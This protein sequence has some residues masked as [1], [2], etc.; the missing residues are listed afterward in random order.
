VV[1]VPPARF[2]LTAPLG[3]VLARGEDWTT[4]NEEVV[5]AGERVEVTPVDGL[6]PR[7]WRA[8]AGTR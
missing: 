8:R 3:T 1:S 2:M 5:D 4:E 6:R 7:A